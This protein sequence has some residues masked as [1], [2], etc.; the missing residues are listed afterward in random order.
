MVHPQHGM[1]QG[2]VCKTLESA[3]HHAIEDPVPAHFFSERKIAANNKSSQVLQNPFS[4]FSSRTRK[5]MLYQAFVLRDWYADVCYDI[6]EL[7]QS[8]YYYYI[9]VLH[10]FTWHLFH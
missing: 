9:N 7:V 1:P 6:L 3:H 5:R 2:F 8:Y 10:R 4:I